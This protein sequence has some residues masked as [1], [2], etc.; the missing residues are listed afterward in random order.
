MSI[1]EEE[2][3]EE[4]SKMLIF[5]LTHICF[6]TNYPVLALGALNIPNYYT[7]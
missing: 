3:K 5:L 7:G 2:E 1:R 4:S 6:P